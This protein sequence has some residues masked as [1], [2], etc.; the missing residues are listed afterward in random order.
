MVVSAVVRL[1]PD[2]LC[3][4]ADG[5]KRLWWCENR[6]DSSRGNLWGSASGMVWAAGHAWC[7]AWRPIALSM[8]LRAPNRWRISPFRSSRCQPRSWR[9]SGLL[10]RAPQ[11]QV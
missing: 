4:F 1:L 11:P 8:E 2:E 7:K 6:Y 10:L 5:C 9:Q 3:D